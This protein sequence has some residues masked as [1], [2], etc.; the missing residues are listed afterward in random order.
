MKSNGAN[1]I[2]G[3]RSGKRA[4]GNRPPYAV[5][6]FAGELNVEARGLTSEGQGK[7]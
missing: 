1:F 5:A 4:A 7:A 2:Y 3:S 6:W